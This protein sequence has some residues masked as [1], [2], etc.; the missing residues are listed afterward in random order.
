MDLNVESVRN[1]IDRD[2]E[3]DLNSIFNQRRLG[4]SNNSPLSDKKDEKES[5]VLAACNP[6]ELYEKL[7]KSWNFSHRRII[8]FHQKKMQKF[9]QIYRLKYMYIFDSS[10]NSSH[11]RIR[12]LSKYT[13]KTS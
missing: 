11:K 6:Y 4:E 2:I 13:V 1:N 8:D 7:K 10:D 9:K 5:L 12:A 3:N